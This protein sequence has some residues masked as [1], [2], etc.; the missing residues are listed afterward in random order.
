[1]QAVQKTINLLPFRPGELLTF[2]KGVGW[3]RFRA[4]QILRWI[5]QDRVRHIQDM[6]NLSLK[7]RAYLEEVAAIGRFRNVQTVLAE[8][9]TQKFLFPLENGETIESILIPDGHR[10]TLCLS[11]QVGCTLDCRFCLTGQM[12]LTRNL[13]SHEIVDQV[14]SVQDTL[15]P[16][17]SL[18]SLVFM[19][20]GGTLSQHRCR[21]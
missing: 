20:M 9:G 11:T 2:V 7:E 13:H 5:Y 12:G 1:M 21:D 16:D 17:Q 15:H 6:T 19:G 3:P 4:E 8:D 18:T 14:L 10:L